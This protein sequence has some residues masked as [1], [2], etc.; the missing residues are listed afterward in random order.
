MRECPAG[1]APEIELVGRVASELAEA[2]RGERDPL[3]LL[4]PEAPLPLRKKSIAT[5]RRQSSLT[6]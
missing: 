3:Q 1:A 2:L 6:D 4:F 5:H